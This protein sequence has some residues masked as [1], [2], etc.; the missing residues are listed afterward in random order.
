MPAQGKECVASSK[1]LDALGIPMELGV[2]VPI[3]LRTHD[4]EG[5]EKYIVE[6]LCFPVTI[7]PNDA[8]HAQEFW[9]SQEWLL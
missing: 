7:S 4:A 2:R 6:N 5:Q 9:V 3:T 1:V 8:A